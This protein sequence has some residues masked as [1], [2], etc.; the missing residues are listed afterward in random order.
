MRRMIGQG[1]GRRR[2]ATEGR[3]T[4]ARGFPGGTAL[5]IY[6]DQVPPRLWNV[7]C[8][9]KAAWPLRRRVCAG[10]RGEVVE[11]GFGSGLN[12]AFYPPEVFGVAAIDPSDV[13]WRLA[14]RRMALWAPP[15]LP[16]K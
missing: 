7:V 1:K 8:G 2:D 11:I 4:T 15:P 9:V 16:A 14:A 12:V 6:R 5:G 10:L 13:G 3:L